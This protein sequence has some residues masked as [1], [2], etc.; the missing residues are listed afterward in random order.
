M[1]RIAMLTNNYKPFIGGVPISIERLSQGLRNLGHEVYIFAPTYENQED[2]PYVL[3]YKSFKKKLKGN[4][5]IPNT[6]DSKIE[7]TFALLNFDIIHVHHP[8][9][10]G[11]LATYLGRKY[12][13]PVAYTYHTRYEQYLHYMELFNKWEYLFPKSE[14]LNR[15]KNQFVPAVIKKF[16]QQCDIIFAPTPLMQTTLENMGVTTPIEIL[17]TGINPKFFKKDL[18]NISK[19]RETYLGDKKFLFCSVSRLSDEK[20]ISFIIRGLCQLKETYGNYFRML[21]IGDGPLKAELESQVATLNLTENVVFIPSVSN[22]LIGDYYRACDLFLF[23]SQ[24]ETQGIVLLEAMAASI[25]VVAIKA[26]GVIDVVKNEINGYM[27]EANIDEW[28]QKIIILLSNSQKMCLMKINAYETAT[29][30]SSERIAM[31]AESYYS[32]AIGHLELER[33]YYAYE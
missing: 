7:A 25:P 24:S 19:I 12:N 20:N 22:D 3:R 6:F 26:S 11:D 9:L 8:V 1:M 15:V 10:C 2:E 5:T 27:T 18:N 31:L 13:I 16:A 32:Q 17:P 23:A 33:E 4:M 28:V 30:Y 14:L 29:H 21:L